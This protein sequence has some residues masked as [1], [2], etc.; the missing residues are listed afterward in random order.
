MSHFDRSPRPQAVRSH[1]ATFAS[2]AAV[3]AVF[4]AAPL[5][6]RAQPPGGGMRGGGMAMM[7]NML[8]EGITLSDAQK[9]RIDS[10]RTA[11]RQAMMAERQGGGM[12]GPPD[13]AT[14]AARR[15]RTEAERK[16]IRD[17]LTA[18]QQK[19][20]DANVA[21]MEERMREMR[22]RRGAPPR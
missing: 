4:S 10:I 14:M 20:F 18:D 2:L 17:V 8:M 19:T 1:L 9:S 3:A 13:S 16:A 15:A 6:L 21:R 22:E 7:Q 11:N 5:A 12:A